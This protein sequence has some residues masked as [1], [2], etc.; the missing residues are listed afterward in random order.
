V[1]GTLLQQV[2][3]TVFRFNEAFKPDRL[4]LVGGDG[5]AVEDFLRQPIERWLV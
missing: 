4:L 3:T 2:S 1:Q 5:I